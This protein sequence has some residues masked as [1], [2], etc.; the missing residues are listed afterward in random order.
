MTVLEAG[1]Y[2][3][4]LYVAPAPNDG[5]LALGGIWAVAP[6]FVRQPLQYLGFRLWDLDTLDELAQAREATQLTQPDAIDFL[7]ELL[8][9]GRAWSNEPLRRTE[10]PIVAVVR[11]RTEFGP[12]AL[13]HRSLLAVPDSIQMRDRLNRL[14]ARQWYRPVAPMIAD[15][16]LE[17]V[18]G[19]SVKSPYMTMA[20]RVRNEV[21]QRF[22]A[23]A[24]VDGSARHQSVSMQDDK[25][26]HTLLSAVGRV[27]GLAA[28]I[29]T[30]FNTQ[31]RPIANRITACLEMLDELEDLD[32][33]L[34]EDWLFKSPLLTHGVRS[35]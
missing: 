15:E 33:L 3:L 14:K 29:N 30:S 2:P 19:R 12:R 4:D 18:F 22:P 26:L 5:G 6:P 23:L 28:L 20:P 7:A 10:K 16:A 1:G 35:V 24:H 25:W 13:G 34:I 32:Y 8:T 17:A 27:T 31:G 21:L 11:G 9:G